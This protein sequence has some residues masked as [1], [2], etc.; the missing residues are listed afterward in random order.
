MSK[1]SSANEMS[2]SGLQAG[3]QFQSLF[4]CM[5]GILI[6]A[7]WPEREACHF[8]KCTLLGALSPL[9]LLEFMPRGLHIDAMKENNMT[10]TLA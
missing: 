10:L 3:V 2:I 5:Q 8:A 6:V 7:K 4:E 1:Q 9:S